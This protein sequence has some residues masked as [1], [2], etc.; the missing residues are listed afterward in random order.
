MLHRLRPLVQ[1][2]QMMRHLVRPTGQTEHACICYKQSSPSHLK[3]QIPICQ[4]VR[5]HI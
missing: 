4:S 2:C 3:R 5:V 1:F